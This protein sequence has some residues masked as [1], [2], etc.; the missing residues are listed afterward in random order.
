MEQRADSIRLFNDEK[1][2][3]ARLFLI[4]TTAGGVGV[5]LFAAN[6]VIIFDVS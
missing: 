3:N 1:N 4:S 2:R 5:N 6:R